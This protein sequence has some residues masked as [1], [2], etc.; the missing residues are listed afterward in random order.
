MYAEDKTSH[1]VTYRTVWERLQDVTLGRPQEVIFQPLKDVSRGRPQDV[2][3]GHLL[4]L[5][6][7]PNVDVHRTPLDVLMASSGRNFAK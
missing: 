5:H 3:R 6:R 1:G 4:T 2:S 7:G